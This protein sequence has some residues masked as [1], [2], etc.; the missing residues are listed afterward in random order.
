MVMRVAQC[1]I[2]SLNTSSGLIENVCKLQEIGILSLTEIWHPEIT[3]LKF[4]HKWIWY[5]SIRNNREGGGAATIIN[6]QIKTHPRKDLDN[7]LLELV[8]CEIYVERRKILLGSVYIPP[9]NEHDM[10]LLIKML[11]MISAG[12]ENVILMGDFNARH[13]M[14]YNEDSNKCKGHQKGSPPDRYE[15]NDQTIQSNQTTS[16]HVGPIAPI[17]TMVKEWTINSKP[18]QRTTTQHKQLQMKPLI[19]TYTPAP[20]SGSV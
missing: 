6:P 1:N 16:F 9:D 17:G 4:L 15:V 5:T 11:N 14:W 19:S 2:R 7:P 8:W 10:E 3:N 20:I 12:N 13:P 18:T